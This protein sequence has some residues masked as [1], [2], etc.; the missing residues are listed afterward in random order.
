VGRPRSASAHARVLEGASRLFAEHGIDGTSMDAI[1]EISGVSKATIYKHWPDKGALCLEVMSS[2]HDVDPVQAFEPSGDPRADLVAF[3][4]RQPRPRTEL[5]AQLWPHLMAYAARHPAFGRA[6]RQQAIDPP[7]VQVVTLLRQAIAAGR[8]SADVDVEAE[9]VALVGPMMYRNMLR[10]TGGEP[11]DHLA[12]VVVGTLWKA[13][14][15]PARRP[16]RT[17]RRASTRT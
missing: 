10:M 8:L 7:R 2:L 14:G 6:W 13:H 16:P 3:L 15:K 9:A 1:A 17:K 4:G 12:D 5:R 11:M